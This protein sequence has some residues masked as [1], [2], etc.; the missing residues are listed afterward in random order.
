MNDDSFEILQEQ[1]PNSLDS[2][3]ERYEALCGRYLTMPLGQLHI[4]IGT[5]LHIIDELSEDQS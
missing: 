3:R 2:V 4:D 5:C 1:T